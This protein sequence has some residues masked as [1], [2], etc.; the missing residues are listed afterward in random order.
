MDTTTLR[1]SLW[2]EGIKQVGTADQ[3]LRSE[4]SVA[5]FGRPNFPSIDDIWCFTV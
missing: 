1:F 4:I 5:R 2:D 3:V